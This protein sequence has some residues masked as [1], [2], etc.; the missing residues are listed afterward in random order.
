MI[1]I[2]TPTGRIGRHVVRELMNAG[3]SVRVVVRNP[4]KLDADVHAYVEIAQG[5]LDNVEL[6][7]QALDGAAALFWC[8]PASHTQDNV[9]DY[10]LHFAN[11]AATAIGQAGMPRIVAVSSGG[12]GR[13]KNA[14]PISA[15]H[16]MEE[17]LNATG[18]AS[19]YLRCGNFMENFLWQVELIAHQGVFFYPFPADFPIP[20]VATQDIGITAAKWLLH[21]DW[22]GQMGVGV[23]G[24][25]D[26][27]LN[28]VAEQIGKAIGKPVRFQPVSPEAYYKSMLQNGSSP[29]Y[30]QGLL[31]MFA[32][33]A[34]G[35]YDAEPRMLETTTP[36]TLQQW[37]KDA[38]VPLM[39][40]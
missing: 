26:L 35:I 33:V 38:L 37:A 12:K 18:A 40:P 31:D 6:L 27:S 39:K 19:R 10:Y 29:A 15:L 30:A 14:G 8:V 34:A 4:D 2:T 24:P 23:H 7:T 1:V 28:Q 16:A 9:Q 5:S 3:K 22:S 36:T 32:E 17:E 21:R 20:M 25:A 13:A 11:A